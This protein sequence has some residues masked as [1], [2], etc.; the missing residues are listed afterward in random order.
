M[1]GIWVHFHSQ[2][3]TDFKGQLPCCY[4]SRV[5]WN[6]QGACIYFFLADSYFDVSASLVLRSKRGKELLVRR[7]MAPPGCRP[8]IAH[9][10]P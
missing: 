6:K 2:K 8:Y 5:K 7:V 10:F 3:P 4:K 9:R 1:S